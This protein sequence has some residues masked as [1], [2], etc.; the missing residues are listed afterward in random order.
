MNKPENS[1]KPIDIKYEKFVCF[2]KVYGTGTI[3]VRATDS[4]FKEAINQ[5]NAVIQNY[6]Y[7]GDMRP[8]EI[9]D[10]LYKSFKTKVEA[11]AVLEFSEHYFDLRNEQEGENIKQGE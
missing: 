11:E 4:N 5:A 6:E 8:F 2:V 3:R 7:I 1:C 10:V 9:E